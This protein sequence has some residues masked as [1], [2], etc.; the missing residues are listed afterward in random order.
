MGKMKNK[1]TDWQNK[2]VE[3]GLTYKITGKMWKCSWTEKE[4][5]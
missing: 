3:E 4:H 1:S 5:P 2:H